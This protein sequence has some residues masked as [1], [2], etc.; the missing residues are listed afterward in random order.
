MKSAVTAVYLFCAVLLFSPLPA[1][2]SVEKG[3]WT[4]NIKISAEYNGDKVEGTYSVYI[5]SKYTGG[6]MTT[7][8]LLHDYNENSSEWIQKSLFTREAEKR[9]YILIA[10][11]MK[12]SAYESEFFPETRSRWS[13]MPG[14]KWIGEY[15]IPHAQ[16]KFNAFAK[17]DKTMVVGT[18]TG[19]RGAYL[20][21][22][23]Y[24]K[25]FKYVG[26]FSGCYDNETLK[27]NPSIINHLGIYKTN[28]ERWKTTDNL[29]ILAENF[30]NVVLFLS[31]GSE[32][33]MVNPDQSMMF[34]VRLNTIKKKNSNVQFRFYSHKNGLHDWGTYNPSIL[35]FLN[36][37][38]E[39]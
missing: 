23:R 33:F 2:D 6:D 15:L 16:K 19:A 32:D 30:S 4:R 29:I 21:L 38:S 39:N 8:L 20:C 5:P 17:R 31:H 9:N 7:V 28:P 3:K 25:Y 18:G 1:D 13:A 37:V 24:P 12:T 11:D 14:I 27:R 10:P 35:N 36:F 26:G 22:A 34:G